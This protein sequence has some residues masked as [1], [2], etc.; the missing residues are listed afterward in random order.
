LTFFFVVLFP[1][2][3]KEWKKKFT[4]LSQKSVHLIDIDKG[5]KI[6]FS[7]FHSPLGCNDFSVHTVNGQD[8]TPHT[9]P[10][11]T[12]RHVYILDIHY[13]FISNKG[14]YKVFALLRNKQQQKKKIY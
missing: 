13:N 2:R 6:T 12:R 11:W 9:T 10:L 8:R 4:E 5:E 1:K 7:L 3:K 14:K